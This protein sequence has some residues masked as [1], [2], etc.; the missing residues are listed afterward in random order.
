MPGSVQHSL[1]TNDLIVLGPPL[2]P[3]YGLFS[4]MSLITVSVAL[5]LNDHILTEV[6]EALKAPK[7]HIRLVDH[8]SLF[9]PPTPHPRY[10]PTLLG[11]STT[12]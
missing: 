9:Y 10:L 12:G 1:Q 5:V 4:Q 2:Q 8:C 11:S 6:L 3:P 7:T